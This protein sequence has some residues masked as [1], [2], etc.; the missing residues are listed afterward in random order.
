MRYKKGD[1][2]YIK[3]KDQL[4]QVVINKEVKPYHGK[5]HYTKDEIRYF[6]SRCEKTP[7]DLSTI[8]P[9]LKSYLESDI[10][11]WEREYKLKELGI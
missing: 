4:I 11:S 9:F 6:V 2:T 8:S 10:I 7:T 1:I 3:V 5:S